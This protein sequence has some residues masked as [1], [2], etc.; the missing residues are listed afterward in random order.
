MSRQEL[1]RA[2]NAHVLAATGR[3][4]SL[5]ANYI[6][7]LE[8]GAIRWPDERY[9]AALCAVLAAPRDADLGFFV[10]RQVE[11]QAPPMVPDSS[12]AAAV[13]DSAP[14]TVAGMHG[15]VA[16]PVLVQIG[17]GPVTLAG[18]AATPSIGANH[19][20][21]V[22]LGGG[23]PL[24]S[25][26]AMGVEAGPVRVV[27][28]V[29]PAEAMAAAELPPAGRRARRRHL[30]VAGGSA[31]TFGEAVK[32]LSGAESLRSVARR[33]HLDPAHLSRM[34]RGVRPPTRLYASALDT[35]FGTDELVALV[36]EVP[37]NLT[38]RAG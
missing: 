7:K 15:A 3:V 37:A 29:G 22:H 9:R 18:P 33:A 10:T 35:A 14:P 21:V 25:S 34:V 4:V 38:G 16:A 24:G 8:R 6:G 2:V 31:K 23:S 13:V 36:S 12:G 20:V 30:T 17:V 11:T 5:D 28:I 27:V 19:A 26:D 1:A 32:R